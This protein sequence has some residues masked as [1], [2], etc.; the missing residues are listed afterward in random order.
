M[1]QDLC[2]CHDTS[3]GAVPSL[4]YYCVNNQSVYKHPTRKCVSCVS[5]IFLILVV[6][7]IHLPKAYLIYLTQERVIDYNLLLNRYSLQNYGVVLKTHP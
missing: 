4:P 1:L 2:I 5:P 3:V 7:T 6:L